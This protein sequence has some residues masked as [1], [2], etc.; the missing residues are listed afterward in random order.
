MPLTPGYGE[1]RVVEPTWEPVTAAEMTGHARTLGIDDVQA[2]RLTLAITEAR[3]FVE[4]LTRRAI[5]QAQWLLTLDAF[6]GRS[7]D[8]F[9][10][11]GWRYGIVRMPRPPLI[12]VDLVQYY[13]TEQGE[14]PLSYTTLATTEYQVDAN[15]EPG[16]LAPAP[17]RVWPQTSPLAMA[18]VK[19]TY[20]AGWATAAAVPARL[21]QA[22]KLVAA[23]IYEHREEAVEVALS[24]LPLGVR[25]FASSAAPWEYA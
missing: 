25:A 12:S 16:R 4:T 20:T 1:R 10:P 17:F 22:I 19:I 14:M 6:P 11:P 5:P 21:K 13:G 9:R 8:D 7:I 3:E 2:G 18:A 23:H 15:T 24:R